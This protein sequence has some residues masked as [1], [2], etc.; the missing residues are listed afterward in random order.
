MLGPVRVFLL[1]LCL[2]YLVGCDRSGASSEYP[3]SHIYLGGGAPSF[4]LL[5]GDVVTV[6]GAQE[7]EVYNLFTGRDTLLELSGAFNPTPPIYRPLSDSLVLDED[8]LTGSAFRYSID[9]ITYWAS[10]E[11][12]FT[13]FPEFAR[14]GSRDFVNRTAEWEGIT[15]GLAFSEYVLLDDYP[16]PILVISEREGSAYGQSLAI[17]V[18][19]VSS[20]G[21]RGSLLRQTSTGQSVT[22]TPITFER[23]STRLDYDAATFVNTVNESYS[24]SYLLFP[25]RPVAD[26]DLGRAA[27]RR[28]PRRAIIDPRDPGRISASFLDDGR[29]MLLSDDGIVLEGNY[30]LD[31]DKGLLTV[32]DGEGTTFRIFITDRPNIVFTLPVTTMTLAGSG[33]RSTDNYLSVEVIP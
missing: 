7:A 30:V 31:L 11:P 23:V 24:D 10:F 29:F 22:V 27:A 9:S 21:F 4:A 16:Q 2:G 20:G 17:R 18:D 32:D 13:G 28:M 26:R 3:I 14:A 6:S 8:Y 5:A 25:P 1:T 15:P 33:V 19:S 12:A